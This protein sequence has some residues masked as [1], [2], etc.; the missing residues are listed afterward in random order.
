MAGEGQDTGGASRGEH[1]SGVKGRR[2]QGGPLIVQL[3]EAEL[4]TEE[5]P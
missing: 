4:V 2:S 3:N 1:H 5:T